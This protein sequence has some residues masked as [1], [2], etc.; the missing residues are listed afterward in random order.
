MG[1]RTITKNR[2]CSHLARRIS[3]LAVI[4]FVAKASARVEFEDAVVSKPI[5]PLIHLNWY[6]Q[7]TRHR[8]ETLAADP[9][10]AILR[11]NCRWRSESVNGGK[12]ST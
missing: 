12:F 7:G 1:E 4:C 10:L 3:F 9:R 2:A 5:I 6:F 8:A 11:R